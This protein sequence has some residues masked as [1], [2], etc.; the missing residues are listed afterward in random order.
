MVPTL[1]CFLRALMTPHTSLRTLHDIE[2]MITIEGLPAL[3]R[4]SRFAEVEIR[5]DGRCFLLSLPLTRDAM[6]YTEQVLQPLQ[7]IRHS[8]WASIEVLSGELRWTDACDKEHRCDL[9]LQALPGSPVSEGIAPYTTAERSA[10]FDRLEAALDELGIAHN[11]L[12]AENLRIDNGRLIPIRWFDLTTDGN[13]ER[14]R[15]AL[16]Q[17]RK[18]FGCSAFDALICSDF[19]ASYTATTDEPA[20][21]TN[22]FSEGLCR[23]RQGAMTGY[24]DHTERFIIPP[25]FTQAGAF[26]ENRAVVC[27]ETGWGVID[28]EGRYVIAPH[29]DR[30]DYHTSCSCFV[31]YRGDLRAQFN[32]LGEQQT[33]F[34]PEG[35]TLAIG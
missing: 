7:R 1:N 12:K 24:V 15:R 3:H 25:Q 14:D 13:R 29:Y 34:T 10:M 19:E 21:A 20:H 8:A 4:T 26:F 2:P 16:T 23:R 17:L 30:I 27:T 35:C 5:R 31:V 6:R 28:R 22:H 11:N 18:E 9:V 33:E 32:Y